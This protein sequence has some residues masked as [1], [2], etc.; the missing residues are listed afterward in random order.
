MIGQAAKK[1]GRGER[2][3]EPMQKEKW[4]HT[5][6]IGTAR[7]VIIQI[8]VISWVLG[9]TDMICSPSDIDRTP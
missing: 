2:K 5:D 3:K 8:T 4:R 6:G 9:L 1:R 7:T